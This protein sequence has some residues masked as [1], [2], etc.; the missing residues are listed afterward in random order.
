MRFIFSVVVIFIEAD[1]LFENYFVAYPLL[2]RGIAIGL[3][4][5][6]VAG[7]GGKAEREAEYLTRGKELYEQ[8]SYT[9]AALEFRNALQINPTEVE[10]QYYLGLI[11]ERGGDLAGALGA[12][13][14]VTEQ[15]PR[16]V[17]AQLKVGQYELLQDAPDKALEKA[18]LALGVDPANAEAHALRGAVMLRQGKLDEAAAEA[19][20]ARKGDPKNVAALSVLI[21]IQTKRGD[22]AGA[23]KM[24]EAAIQENPKDEGL[25][26]IKLKLL[27]DRNDRP[28]T[29]AVLRD[30]VA[31]SPANNSYKISL[32]RLLIAQNQKDE[33][34][35]VF[36]DAIQQRP[37]DKALKL[38][39]VQF[40]VQQR[41]AEAGE[42]ELLTISKNAPDDEDYRFALAELYAQQGKRDLAKGILSEI[43][44]K[45]ATAPESLTA[46][47]GLAKL[48]LAEQDTAA[49]Q[50]LVADILKRDRGNAEAL[51]IKAGM[52]LT[53]KDYQATIADL[54]TILR[55]D[56][57]S[58]PGLLLLARAYGESG[59]QQ[60]TLD[61]YRSYLGVD[62]EN[63]DIRI[64]FASQLMRQTQLDE[65]E[66]QVEAILKRSPK[67]VPALL[68]QVDQRLARK[69]VA[70]AE[71]AASWIVNGAGAEIPGR[72]ALGKVLLA[73]GKYP[74]AIAALK[75][76]LEGNPNPAQARRM[77]AQAMVGAG[78]GPAAVDLLNAAITK[79]PKDAE[80][81]ILLA[82]TQFN[83]KQFDAAEKA[84]R[85]SIEVRPDW[86]L[87]YLKLGNLYAKTDKL[88]EAEAVF[89][90]GLKQVPNQPELMLNLGMIE[91][92]R[93]EFDAARDVYTA[94][95]RQQPRNTIAA[96]NLAALI[97]D[98]WP[99]DKDRMEQARRLAEAFRNSNDPILV[100][101]LGW[102]QYRLGN[103]DDAVSLL[104]RAVKGMPEH[105]QLRY[106]LGMAY[107]ARGDA[108]KARAEL[109]RAI[110]V[111]TTYRGRDDAKSALAAL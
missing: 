22:E 40:L 78:Q 38:L 47:A 27:T 91:D 2:R 16:H 103:V 66:K 90:A 105:P 3:M 26:L 96:N 79:D 35:K 60:L 92:S 45:D 89:A 68:L 88:A 15:D 30:L 25:K 4:L 108:A 50:A 49:A 12:F 6:A 111:P 62:P 85:Q 59:E 34:E 41:G 94:L 109:Q 10:G 31:A 23:L 5:L 77:L 81:L 32:A 74:E 99:T 36:R 101:T 7:C 11:A 83:L 75:R 28:G 52:D 17:P 82:D 61:A 24:V 110:V 76:A 51:L 84:L 21:G 65:A 64:E 102:V 37:K 98:A 14:K 56:P 97:A 13:T 48:A 106:H 33:A 87:P 42:Q 58:K 80:L 39:L 53:A 67:Y 100:D 46:K 29:E 19:E 107:K 9:K 43:V 63:D 69:N 73:E 71:E 20:K 104:E 72:T 95:L 55:D 8:G 70:G 18:D 54:R 57:A 93:D 86:E 44:A 1:T